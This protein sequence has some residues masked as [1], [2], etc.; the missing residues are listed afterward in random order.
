[1]VAPGLVKQQAAMYLR[2][3]MPPSPLTIELPIMETR[4]LSGIESRIWFRCD[5]FPLL[6]W[7]RGFVVE[8][9][10]GCGAAVAASGAKRL[11]HGTVTAS[12]GPGDWVRSLWW[13]DCA[14]SV[15]ANDFTSCLLV[16][17]HF[18]STFFTRL[19]RETC[20]FLKASAAD[21]SLLTSLWMSLYTL[22]VFVA[23][24]VFAFSSLWVS[25]C[26]GVVDCDRGASELGVLY[27]KRSVNDTSDA[28]WSHIGGS[29]DSV[30]IRA[31]LGCDCVLL[32]PL[33]SLSVRVML[34]DW[35]RS[36]CAGLVRVASRLWNSTF[37]CE[38][39]SDTCQELFPSAV[40]GFEWDF[41]SDT[42]LLSDMICDCISNITLS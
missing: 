30:S 26:P 16:F 2:V 18:V 4:A 6:C 41:K 32:S 39:L 25:L 40:G 31:F 17:L 36:S 37:L 1:M 3:T 35:L 11:W 13:E 42:V 5:D 29:S 24:S 15:R 27:A 21:F 28:S 9:P 33:Q 19:W 34:D 38:S 23:I 8:V 20:D 14:L 10:A 12:C 7:G 22:H